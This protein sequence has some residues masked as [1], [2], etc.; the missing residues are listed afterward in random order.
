MF[1]KSSEILLWK[2]GNRSKFDSFYEIIE[3]SFHSTKLWLIFKRKNSSIGWR[4]KNYA[5]WSNFKRANIEAAKRIILKNARYVERKENC[6]DKCLM[7]LALALRKAKQISH[8][9]IWWKLLEIWCEWYSKHIFLCWTLHKSSKVE[10]QK[11][12]KF[13]DSYIFKG[14]PLVNR[15]NESTTKR[16]SG[17]RGMFLLKSYRLKN[18]FYFTF[19]L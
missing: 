6:H 9:N 8:W 18:K 7:S 15:K 3:Y 11:M 10:Q 5:C 4:T 16:F 13:Y 1:E 17:K 14:M 12:W 19:E 2:N